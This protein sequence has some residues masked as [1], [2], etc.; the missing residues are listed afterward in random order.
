MIELQ[1]APLSDD[2]MAN[3]E[4]VGDSAGPSGRLDAEALLVRALVQEVHTAALITAGA[5][6]AVN[7]ATERRGPKALSE[8][9]TL[10][11]E[12][13]ARID[14][15]PRRILDEQVSGAAIEDISGF[16][17]LFNDARSRLLNFEREAINIGL[18]RAG[19]LHL[20]SLTTA[21]RLTC[22]HALVAVANLTEEASQ[23]LPATYASNMLTLEQLLADAIAGGGHLCDDSGAI[24]LPQMAE[25]RRTPRR[26]LLQ[27]AHVRVGNAHVLAFAKDVSLGG[28]GLT[29][30]PPADV[31]TSV[32]VELSCGRVLRGRIAWSKGENSGMRFDRQ[33]RPTDP[34]LFG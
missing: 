10:T 2:S 13:P 6:S 8:A 11:V 21:W 4:F 3:E 7:I 27:S 14:D 12:F 28:L 23:L 17:A 29:R 20:R 24:H 26:S 33:L 25:R 5:A 19:T 1:H 9:R 30:M 16:Y 31:G 22:R 15:W 32:L 34:L 18:D